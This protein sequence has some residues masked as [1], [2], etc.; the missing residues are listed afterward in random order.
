[1]VD[2]VPERF[3]KIYFDWM[4]NIE[5]WCI[6]RQ[7]WW[8]HRI[9]AWYG[10]QG[11]IYVGR[12]APEGD[13]WIPEE[14]VL[15][16]WFS[17]ALWPFSTLGWPEETEDYR[18]YYPT[19]VMETGYDILFFWVAR[20]I[21]MGLWFTGKV[22]FHTVY[23]H[24]LV[25]DAQGRKISKTLGNAIDPIELM[26]KY[27]TD[28]LRFTLVTSGTPGNDVNLDENRIESNWRFV[29]KIWQITNF[30]TAN[31]EGDL[32]SGLPPTD[33]LDL[34][35]RWILS[36]LNTLVQNT[37]RLFDN[38]LFG[39]PGRQIYD[40][41]WGEF[42]AWY[43]EISKHK[44]YSGSPQEKEQTSRVLVHVLDTCLR[45]LHPYMPFVT[46]AAWNY[47]PHEGETI[48]LARWPEA[49]LA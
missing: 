31:I 48:M 39:E 25:R 10:P 20:M 37:Q 19:S 34:P 29:N 16:T 32:P 47:L 28:P 22:P 7:L 3:E 26:D 9:P 8:G 30:V 43:I 4:E 36:R 42:A 18:R 17:S 40:F 33:E 44:L 11:E 45:L 46:E 12:Q 21:M 6:S 35:A 24:G 23:L 38:Y 1:P 14:D 15:D 49:D 5:D 13:G 27:G 2:I 41:L